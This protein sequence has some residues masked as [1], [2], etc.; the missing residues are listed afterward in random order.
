M[1]KHLLTVFILWFRVFRY[2][3]ARVDH[4]D[5]FDIESRYGG[6]AYP[7]RDAGHPVSRL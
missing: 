1:Q 5:H 6:D 4:F 7:I 3:Q 2:D